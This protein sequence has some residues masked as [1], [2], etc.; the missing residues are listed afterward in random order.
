MI[1][2][3][4][5]A[6][7]HGMGAILDAYCIKHCEQGWKK[8]LY[9]N[10]ECSFLDTL[11]IPVFLILNL[12]SFRH[13]KNKLNARKTTTGNQEKLQSQEICLFAQYL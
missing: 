6:R 9:N 7:S 12:N 2:K 13:F 3:S 4:L 5:F 1:K 11:G 8:V 10:R